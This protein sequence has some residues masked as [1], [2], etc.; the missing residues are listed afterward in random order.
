MSRLHHR[1][2]EQHLRR[3]ATGER[4]LVSVNV[5]ERVH[6]SSRTK[7]LRNRRCRVASYSSLTPRVR[8]LYYSANKQ[9]KVGLPE[10]FKIKVSFLI[11]RIETNG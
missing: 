8:N 4:K 9:G 3:P 11:Q 7:N 5:S 1:A 6:S 10:Q 2:W